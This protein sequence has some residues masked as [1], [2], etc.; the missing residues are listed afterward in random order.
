MEQVNFGYSLKNI[1]IP[2]K[3]VYLQMLISSAEKVIQAV[4]WRTANYL[5]PPKSKNKKENFGFRSTKP[6]PAVPELKAFEDDV[7]KLVESVKFN[8]KTNDFQEKLKKRLLR[9]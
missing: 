7:L 3:K 2:E 6:D 9:N 4:R 1:A 5:N 8:N